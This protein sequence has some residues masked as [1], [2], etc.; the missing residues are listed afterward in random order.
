MDVYKLNNSLPGGLD[1]SLKDSD[2]RIDVEL[3][4]FGSEHTLKLF[5]FVSLLVLFVLL[6]SLVKLSKA[7]LEVNVI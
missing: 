1:I 3:N 4:L 6:V 5:N 7:E 2:V